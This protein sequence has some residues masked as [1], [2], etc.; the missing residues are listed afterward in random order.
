M[1]RFSEKQIENLL[2]IAWWNFDI[3]DIKKLLPYITSDDIETFIQK[4]REIKNKHTG[5]NI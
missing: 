3:E 5:G 2:D 4:A 1:Q